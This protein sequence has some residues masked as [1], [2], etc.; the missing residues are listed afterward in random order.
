MNADLLHR[1]GFIE[2]AGTCI[3]RMQEEAREQ[4]CPGP[5]FEANG[6]VTVRREFLASDS[7]EHG[8]AANHASGHD[9]DHDHANR[10][11]TGQVTDQVTDHV[12]QLVK[13]P[14]YEMDRAQGQAALQSGLIEMT[15]PD[16]PN[17]RNQRYRLTSEGRKLVRSMQEP[18]S[19]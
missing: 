10:H 7:G 1:T 19:V 3:L 9:H 4:G 16:K 8:E 14:T 6:L 11:A 15:I 17:S 13:T 12:R 18:R 2:K 5:E